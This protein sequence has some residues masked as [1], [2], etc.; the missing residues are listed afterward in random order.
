[1]E[2]VNISKIYKFKVLKETTGGISY[3]EKTYTYTFKS[4]EVT[5]TATIFF[6]VAGCS[7]FGNDNAVA[8]VKFNTDSSYKKCETV[9]VNGKTYYKVE[10]PEGAKNFTICRMLP[11]GATY[12][13][14]TV[15]LATGK[16][17]WTA[18]SGLGG[19]TWSQ[20]ATLGSS[21]YGGG[22]NGGGSEEKKETMTVY[23]VNNYNWNGTIKAYFWGSS[24]ESVSWPG[25][26][27]TYVGKDSSGKAMYKLEIPTDIVGLIFTN[28]STQTVD[29]TANLKDGAVFSISGNSGSKYSVTVK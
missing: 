9:T 21:T 2:N 29:I 6:D 23:F 8:A 14:V 26:A 4:A 16:N 15:T 28:G 20:N 11:S 3:V 7:W 27:M 25:V 1:M 13:A 18:N 12:N 22:S 24:K 17:L 10:V 5:T 19:G